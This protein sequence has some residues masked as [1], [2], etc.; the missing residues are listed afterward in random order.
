[1]RVAL[2]GLA[3]SGLQRRLL[4]TALPSLSARAD[5]L[6]RRLTPPR[7]APPSLKLVPDAADVAAPLTSDEPDATAAAD[8][9]TKLRFSTAMAL[10]D[11]RERGDAPLIR[12]DC[13]RALIQARSTQEVQAVLRI[14]KQEQLWPGPY[15]LA[16]AAH[17][18]ARDGRR[19]LFTE[20]LQTVL[21]GRGMPTPETCTVLLRGCSMC[22]D[23]EGALAVWSR[24]KESGLWPTVPGLQHLLMACANA[25]AWRP[26]LDVLRACD[27][28]FPDGPAVATEVRQWNAVLKA[29]VRADAMG[30]REALD[31]AEELI[32]SL[33]SAEDAPGRAA[34]AASY[35]TLLRGFAGEWAG[36]QGL[37][38]RCARVERLLARMDACGIARD[39]YTYAALLQLHKLDPA[40]ALELFA[41][42]KARGITCDRAIY[43]Q[44]VRTL[45]WAKLPEHA[46][47]L[48]EGM[49]SAGVALDAG[50]YA[51]TIRA[52]ESVGLHDDADR[53]YRE[54]Q[55][56]GLGRDLDE[57]AQ[58]RAHERDGERRRRATGSGRRDRDAR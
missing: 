10:V 23:A 49:E 50:F 26:A 6:Q 13:T 20:T 29:C 3:T 11:P 21:N 9:S 37:T 28:A 45:W 12:G 14:M 19:S 41:D 35:N 51:S 38:A 33:P 43:G 36:G 24:M 25:G 18:F 34:N 40:K 16:I 47:Q 17:A 56:R 54:A 52:A 8:S 55:K 44:V 42:A 32:E 46:W 58:S 22:K 4:S 15:D 48:I 27:D 7:P 39:E 57:R 30:D 31:A 2:R 1:M 53:L 5:A